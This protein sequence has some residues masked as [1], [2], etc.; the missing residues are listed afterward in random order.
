MP[1]SA[2]LSVGR[3]LY[4]TAA[5]L[6]ELKLLDLRLKAG[7]RPDQ[8]RVPAGNRDGGQWTDEGTARLSR[9]SGRGGRSRGGGRWSTASPAQ[10]TR[11]AL[12]ASQMHAALNN[13]RRIDPKWRPT[14]QLFETIEG[15]I[16]ANHATARQA[17]ARLTELQRQGI[18]PGPF[19]AE[20]IPARG[21]GRKFTSQ[22]RQEINRIGRESGCHTC[23]TR[24]PAPLPAILCRTISSRAQSTAHP[25]GRLCSRNA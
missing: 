9:A 3:L 17:R 25:P 4:S 6:V 19:A 10:Q 11:L 8:P 22:E 1:P 13:I 14:P 2:E 7:F 21:A 18:G 15:Q 5:L 23:G 24:R 20:S 12:S 16:A